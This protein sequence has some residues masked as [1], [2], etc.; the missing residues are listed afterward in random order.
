[1]TF[2]QREKALRWVEALRSGNYPQSYGYLYRSEGNDNWPA[3]YCCLGVADYFFKEE[4][5]L[6]KG[7]DT[8]LDDQEFENF[9]GLPEAL[10]GLLITLNDSEKAD[11][12]LIADCIESY[13]VTSYND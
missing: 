8:S 11:F 9:F 7:S 5:D 13:V 10:L 12:D 4:V 2:E 3:G 6:A 1:M